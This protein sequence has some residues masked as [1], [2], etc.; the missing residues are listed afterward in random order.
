MTAKPSGVWATAVGVARVRARET[1]RE[2][3][4]FLDPLA[5]AF[6]VA[7]GLPVDGE[8]LHAPA[9][10]AARRR[11]GG[12]GLSIVVRT[13][14]LDELLGDA[15]AAGCRQVVLLGAGMDSRAY[16]LDWPSGTRLFEIDTAEPLDFKES[17]LRTERAE[18][19]CKRIT[20]PVDL[21]DDWPGAL[22]ASGHDPALPTVWIAEGLLIYLPQDAVDRLLGQVGELSASG[23]RMGL[24]L[25]QPGVLERF[26]Q[27]T[28]TPASMWLSE[29]PS[30]PVTWLDG[31]GW[32]AR[33]YTLRERAAAYG[34]PVATPEAQPPRHGGLISAVRR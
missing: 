9:D 14:F 27:D 31:L 33:A 29:M 8:P 13:R 26:A 23:S 3:P 10:E 28:G 11:W 17:V 6:T 20:V 32:D 30:D 21:R 16:R 18:P 19:R 24:T 7:G 34:R 25:G 1:R 5:E 22:S 2:N 12:I 15:A 4:L